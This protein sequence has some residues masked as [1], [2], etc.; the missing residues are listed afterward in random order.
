M[1]VQQILN[2]IY[3]GGD[4]YYKSPFELTKTGIPDMFAGAYAD[5]QNYKQ[6]TNNIN[7]NYSNQLAQ[8]PQVSTALNS[9]KPSYFNTVDYR[10]Q[11]N[12]I[13]FT[14]NDYRNNPYRVEVPYSHFPQDFKD[15]YNNLTGAA[16]QVN[17]LP[18][19]KSSSFKIPD[20]T[21][22]K[23]NLEF[24]RDNSLNESEKRNNN[25]FLNDGISAG[26]GVLGK[27]A[28]Y[29]YN[30]NTIKDA[31]ERTVGNYIPAP[32]QN[33]YNSGLDNY[34]GQAGGD[35]DKQGYKDNSP[36][37]NSSYLDI[38]SPSITMK[39]VSQPLLAQTDQGHQQIM[40]PNK[41][42]YF[43]GANVVRE[44]PIYEDGGEYGGY[45][46]S[47]YEEDQNPVNNNGI[48]NNTASNLYDPSFFNE[49]QNVENSY[50]FSL[51]GGLKE[52]IE[53]M[54]ERNRNDPGFIDWSDVEGTEEEN[55]EFEKNGTYSDYENFKKSTPI[56]E[57]DANPQDKKS[58]KIFSVLA[59]YKE[60]G[61]NPT[62]VN[63]GTHNTGS[64]HYQDLA[65]DFGLN[66]SFGGD[67]KKMDQFRDNFI[68][69]QAKF[70]DL[71]LIDERIRPEGQKEWGGSHWHV[72]RTAQ[73]GGKVNIKNT[74]S[75][76]TL[77]KY[78]TGAF[79]DNQNLQPVEISSKKLYDYQKTPLNNSPQLDMLNNRA[80]NIHDDYIKYQWDSP[81]YANE[82]AKKQD[83][84]Q[85]QYKALDNNDQNTAN[86]IQSQLDYTI[87]PPSFDCLGGSCMYAN[88]FFNKD[89]GLPSMDSVKEPLLKRT[90]ENKAGMSA[91]NLFGALKEQDPSQII[92]SVPPTVGEDPR[93]KQDRPV[94]RYDTLPEDVK[95]KI[96]VG[97]SIGFFNN[98]SRQGINEEN[99]IKD[100]RHHAIVV[101]FDKDKTPLIFDYGHVTRIDNPSIGNQSN[102][103]G[104]NIGAIATPNEY[105]EKNIDFD[106]YSKLPISSNST[107]NSYSNSNFTNNKNINEAS[108]SLT[109]N[110]KSIQEKLGINDLDY[111]RLAS[112]LLA[113]GQQ[114]NSYHKDSPKD[115]LS[116]TGKFLGINNNPSQGMYQIKLNNA[117]EIVKKYNLPQ[118]YGT[119]AGLRDPYKSSVLGM[120]L[121]YETDQ[122]SKN[123]YNEGLDQHEAIETKPY[124]NAVSKFLANH[125]IVNKLPL[126]KEKNDI[127]TKG[128]STDLSDNEKFFYGWNSPYK[129]K[130]GQAQGDSQ[131]SKNLKS[132]LQNI[133]IDFSKNNNKPKEEEPI[134]NNDY[135]NYNSFQSGGFNTKQFL[136]KYKK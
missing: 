76:M 63:T 33:K 103:G 71:K 83:L 96:V 129:L 130:T 6:E 123:W 3:Q 72:E 118:D 131:Y 115:F 24:K 48:S 11:L 132:I 125:S 98:L 50:E 66:G 106:A 108:K 92:F 117:K 49:S 12:N 67:Q 124:D 61:I 30:Q 112:L 127:I 57:E 39:G 94:Y 8:L 55:K 62:S 10:T 113:E 36:Y 102:N 51:E 54:D 56:A 19:I 34:Y 7:Q 97:S 5:Y 17:T 86:N 20:N 84:E 121:A 52:Q 9:E 69:A 26:I 122:N 87:T 136:S 45:D 23:L 107:P 111:N 38:H 133:H 22:D 114:E 88:R 46:Y 128:N 70:P 126:V 59:Y 90:S 4:R 29:T 32:Y 41:D 95:N 100:T 40:Y 134:N 101:G 77:G 93:D 15:W 25:K 81:K 42:Y 116:R 82:K 85:Q 37:R 21:I 28:N 35:I 53:A 64:K 16:N 135:D 109:D 60:L 104:W 80:Q 119:M 43:E 74:L 2:R 73:V 78:Q 120:Y 75:Q 18:T 79:I 13:P 105:K 31:R 14:K 47:R 110:K 99:G 1:N 68:N 89:F 91:W 44:S 58:G 27:L 65:A